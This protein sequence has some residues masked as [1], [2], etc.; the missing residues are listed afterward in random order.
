MKKTLMALV[1]VALLA[2]G[3]ASADHIKANGHDGDDFAIAKSAKGNAFGHG[4]NDFLKTEF[5]PGAFLKNAGNPGNALFGKLHNFFNGGNN[6]VGGFR[7]LFSLLDALFNGNYPILV[8][9]EIVEEEPNNSVPAP[10]TLALLGFGLLMLGLARR[11]VA[12]P[13]TAAV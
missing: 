3:S 9:V 7:G 12:R 4:L 2:F 8:A 11:R 10:G 13:V 1:S 6:R 5:E